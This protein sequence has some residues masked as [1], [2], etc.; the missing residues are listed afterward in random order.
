MYCV[1]RYITTSGPTNRVPS[2]MRVRIA[3]AMP[4]L[5]WPAIEALGKRAAGYV[6]SC[7][8]HLLTAE[9]AVRACGD[10][11]DAALTIGSAERVH[12]RPRRRF[13]RRQAVCEAVHQEDDPSVPSERCEHLVRSAETK[14]F[15]RVPLVSKHNWPCVS[16]RWKHKC[17]YLFG[18]PQNSFSR[19]TR[20]PR[21]PN[22]YATTGTD[23]RSNCHPRSLVCKMFT[24]PIGIG[25]QFATVL[26]Y[27]MHFTMR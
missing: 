18:C 16:R 17:P 26:S 27:S 15:T 5:K 12:G 3:E 14:V 2:V 24:L 20:I 21:A 19:R 4:H 22:D 10:G 23:T 6:L 7:P 1:H 8:T 9:S 13:A 11:A 25:R